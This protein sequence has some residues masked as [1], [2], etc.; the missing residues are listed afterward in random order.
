MAI[1]SRAILLIAA[2]SVVPAGAVLAQSATNNANDAGGAGKIGTPTYPAGTHPTPA[3]TGK[4]G[5]STAS[6]SRAGNP[7][8]PGATGKTVVPGNNSTIGSDNEAT[9]RQKTGPGGPASGG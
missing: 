6:T 8:Q 7:H 4:M 2:L 3:M 1:P 9:T 5:R